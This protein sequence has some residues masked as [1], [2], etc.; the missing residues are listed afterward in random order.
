M[1]S[2]SEFH[3]C[4]DVQTYNQMNTQMAHSLI[5]LGEVYPVLSGSLTISILSWEHTM[6]GK[7]GGC[8]S[9]D[10]MQTHIHTIIYTLAKAV[11]QLAWFQD[12]TLENI[13]QTCWGSWSCSTKLWTQNQKFYKDALQM[14][15]LGE[16]P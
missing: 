3:L 2:R 10:T 16:L 5:L 13:G 11:H 15:P 8:P 1:I 7:I 6:E 9:Q 14:Y 12:K 4:S